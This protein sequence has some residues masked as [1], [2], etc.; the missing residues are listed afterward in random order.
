MKIEAADI[1]AFLRKKHAR[2]LHTAELRLSSGFGN[3]GRIDFWAMSATPS[4]GNKATAYEI[5]V[6]RADFKR[7]TFDKQRGA[8]LL[9][10][11]FYY[12]TPKGLISTEEVPDWA[13]LIEVEWRRGARGPALA[14]KT[15]IPAPKRDKDAPSWGLVCSL[16]RNTQKYGGA[17]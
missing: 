2:D 16:I 3:A 14:P 9:S 12:I 7:D 6:S 17:L 15:I 13:G 5:K 8:R 4:D 10:D 11:L 1:V